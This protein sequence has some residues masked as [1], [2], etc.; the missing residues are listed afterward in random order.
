MKKY[1]LSIA[2]IIV[3]SQFFSCA[4]AANYSVSSPV[5]VAIKKYKA[6][7]Y[8]GC[9]QDMQSIVSRDPSNA[10]AYYYMAMAYAQAGKKDQAI[11]SYQKVLGLKPN[12]TL[13]TYAAKGKRCLETPD[14]CTDPTQ[15][16]SDIDKMVTS[17]YGDGLSNT[18]R[19]DVEK[20]HLDT[21]KNE[22]NADKDVNNYEL[23]K[24]RDYTNQHSELKTEGKTASKNSDEPSN[25]EIVAAL[26]VLTKAGLNPYA[27]QNGVN[28]YQYQ[29]MAGAQNTEMAQLNMLMNGNNQ[30]NNNNN[31]SM[32][33]MIPM[34]MAQS[35]S[36]QGGGSSYNPQMMQAMMMNSMLPDM[37][38]T[39]N[40]NNK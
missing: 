8:T 25:D 28:P 29:Q 14:K 36:G 5:K 11:T 1:L 18:V 30:G 23:R 31:N 20:K 13:Y 2:L 35:K 37:N 40:D 4:F 26:K 33:N 24:F 6:G 34:M 7:N 22:I 17:P 9:L 19:V 32:M 27:Q 21:L 39:S 3:F 15:A 16:S 10:I 38:F 12:A